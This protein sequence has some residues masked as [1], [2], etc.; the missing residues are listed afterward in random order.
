MVKRTLLSKHWG[1]EEHADR[2]AIIFN[3]NDKY[4]EVELWKGTD[5][6]ETRIMKSEYD[7]EVYFHSESYADSCAENYC[8]GYMG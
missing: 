7:D 6:I 4:Y 2:S 8:L 1:Q 5:L 3:V